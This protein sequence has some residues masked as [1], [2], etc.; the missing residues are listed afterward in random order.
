MLYTI[1]NVKMV[2]RKQPLDLFRGFLMICGLWFFLKKNFTISRYNIYNHYSNC[3]QKE[4]I[5]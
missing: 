1:D 3:N 4:L 2:K 5:R